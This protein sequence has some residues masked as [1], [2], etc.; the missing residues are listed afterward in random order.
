MRHLVL[1][2][3][4][5]LLA[6]CQN[7]RRSEPMT[8]NDAGDLDARVAAV[9]SCIDAQWVPVEFKTPSCSYLPPQDGFLPANEA[10]A[11][12]WM[13]SAYESE[14][15][16]SSIYGAAG[17]QLDQALAAPGHALATSELDHPSERKPPAII[18][19]IDETIVDNDAFN[20][21]GLAKRFIQFDEGYFDCWG[22]EQKA[23]GYP[24][25]VRLLRDAEAKGATVF[26]VTNRRENQRTPVVET[27]RR[28]GFPV[29][30]DGA[31][32][33]F[34][35]FGGTNDD[36]SREKG[37]RRQCVASQFRVAMMFGDNL[38]DF[39]DHVHQRPEQR[40]ALATK[41]G[42]D[43]HWGRTWFMLPN[44][45]YGSWLAVM[46]G[47]RADGQTPGSDRERN[48]ESWADPQLPDAETGTVQ[49]S[50]ESERTP[51]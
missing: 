43:S 44:P 18:V 33:V 50:F 19:D 30:A 51:Q 48:L 39:V 9:V 46:Q 6:A 41:E 40:R 28:E 17:M 7:G 31:N 22:A 1:L 24:A 5:V 2:S 10:Y 34:R 4:L 38:G 21:R 42:A 14:A 32:V 3:S 23:R 12:L 36:G 16:I 25:A 45:V 11:V 26:Y 20:A 37:P 15:V 35:N 13:Q 8:A 47:F 29:R 27:L 49:E